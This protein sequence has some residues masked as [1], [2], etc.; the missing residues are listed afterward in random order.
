MELVMDKALTKNAV[1]IMQA[2][3][4]GAKIGRR[5]GMI[6]QRSSDWFPMNK[7]D[8]NWAEYEYCILEDAPSPPTGPF[9]PNE[10][11][12]CGHT[13]ADHTDGWECFF[14]YNCDCGIFEPEKKD[15]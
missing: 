9:L 1:T 3:A 15:D 2:Y 12:E 5:W 7:P 8:W 11:C 6:G 14:W 10:K 13:Y 4:N